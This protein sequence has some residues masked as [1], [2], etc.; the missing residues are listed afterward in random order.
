MGYIHLVSP[1]KSAARNENISY[2]S[3]IIQ[4]SEDLYRSVS[5]REDFRDQLLKVEKNKKKKN[6]KKTDVLYS[7]LTLRGK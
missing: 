2:Y 6:K 7:Y 1:V 5:C 3:M 4:T